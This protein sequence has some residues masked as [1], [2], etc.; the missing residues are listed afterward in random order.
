MLRKEARAV[1]GP[2]HRAGCLCGIGRNC[3]SV[4]EYDSQDSEV[5]MTRAQEQRLIERA[6]G[7]DRDSA[8]RLL[9]AHQPSLYA[10]ML[11]LS[12]RPDVAEDIV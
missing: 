1:I 7:G 12:G 2:V 5:G 9:K 3:G 10:Y 6:V 8:E 11:R 4:I